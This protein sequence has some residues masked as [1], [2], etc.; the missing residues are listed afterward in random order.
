MSLPGPF[1][2]HPAS[3]GVDVGRLQFSGNPPGGAASGGSS[4]YPW[5]EQQRGG[6][7]IDD[8]RQAPSPHLAEPSPNPRALNQQASPFQ[9]APSERPQYGVRPTQ[10]APSLNQQPPTYQ[11][12]YSSYTMNEWINDPPYDYRRT[13][14][15]DQL[16]HYQ[17]QGLSP[18]P[19]GPGPFTAPNYRSGPRSYSASSD[20]GPPYTVSSGYTPVTVPSVASAPAGMPKEYQ[21]SRNHMLAR[22]HVPRSEGSVPVSMSEDRSTTSTSRGPGQKYVPQKCPHCEEVPR[23]KSDYK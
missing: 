17:P 6:L 5:S 18:H 10:G 23:C 4:Y 7:G 19:P 12:Q 16:T 14:P 15:P 22:R 9:S 8:H 2:G 20:T 13:C 11:G 3:I 21:D 1:S